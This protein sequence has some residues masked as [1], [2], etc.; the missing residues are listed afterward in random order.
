MNVPQTHLLEYLGAEETNLLV[1]INLCKRDMDFFPKLDG[2]FQ[3]PLK[4]IDLKIKN[5]AE[6]TNDDRHRMTVLTLYLYVHYHLYS[7]LSTMLR[8]HL[9]DALA[10]TRKA[11]D[12]AFTAVRLIREPA[13]L[14]DYLERHA[15]YR[16][17][18]RTVAEANKKQA[19]E[20]PDTGPLVEMHEICSQFGSHADVSSFI[21]R[22]EIT[23]PDELGKS[24][25]RLMMFQKPDS[26]LEFRYYVVQVLASFAQ[27]LW[28]FGN[29]VGDLAKGIEKEKWVT[30]IRQTISAIQKESEQIEAAMKKPA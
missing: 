1:S 22:V 11:I 19:T 29:F 9:S 7:A 5:R 21:H 10:Q 14:N 16:N 2:L 18:K 23:E 28:L 8:C 15:D 24:L 4:H 17:I 27:M 12:A 6:L 3:E 13:T 20:Y 30:V 26:D 25:M